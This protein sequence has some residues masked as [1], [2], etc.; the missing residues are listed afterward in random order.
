MGQEGFF[1]PYLEHGIA[2][3]NNVYLMTIIQKC[4][5]DSIINKLFGNCPSQKEIDDYLS[6]YFGFY[7]YFTDT[8]VDPLIILVLCKNIFIQ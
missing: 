2:H 1:W 3:K 8:Q 4:T 5:N 7:L 6:Q